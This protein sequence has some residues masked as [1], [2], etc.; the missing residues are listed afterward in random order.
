M[1][2][3][4]NHTINPCHNVRTSCVE[5]YKWSIANNTPPVT[6][7]KTAIQQ[8]AEKMLLEQ[9]VVEWDD[10]STVHD[11]K[12][13]DELPDLPYGV[14]F[15]QTAAYILALDAINFCSWSNDTGR[16]EYEDAQTHGMCR[17]FSR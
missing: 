12:N 9:H 10:G 5:Y 7:Y 14:R 4:S 13:D 2:N 11:N 1:N 15:E 17:S 3:A 16:F 6:I 8:L